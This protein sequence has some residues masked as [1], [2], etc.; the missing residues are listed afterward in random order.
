MTGLAE[1]PMQDQGHAAVTARVA[2]RVLVDRWFYI[3]MAFCTI[4]VAVLGFAPSIVNTAA[5]K[6]PPTLLIAAHGVVSVAWLAMFLAQTT[7][8]AT[9]RIPVH[10][11][12]GTA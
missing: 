7:L 6:A 1:L 9:R 10:R 4:I 8:A 3:A 5:R 2:S 11:R 12:L